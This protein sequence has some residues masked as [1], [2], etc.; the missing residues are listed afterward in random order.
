MD[1]KQKFYNCNEEEFREFAKLND[2]KFPD[3]DP[4]QVI[5]NQEK[6]VKKELPI[7]KNL[8]REDDHSKN[9]ENDND[10]L[11]TNN[12][13]EKKEIIVELNNDEKIVY[14]QLGI[15]PLIKLGK[16]Y[17]TSNHFVRLEDENNKEK[18]QA[19]RIIVFFV[20]TKNWIC[21]HYGSLARWPYL[22]N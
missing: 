10:M 17:L 7:S 13:K 8:I 4:L 1:Q 11:N 15:N 19:K 22:I 14:S 12:S 6:I 21:S 20:K 18:V 16:Q 3:L 5:E 9:K 2:I